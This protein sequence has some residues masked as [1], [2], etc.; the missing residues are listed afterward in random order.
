MGNQLDPASFGGGAYLCGGR[1]LFPRRRRGPAF[2]ECFGSD[3]WFHPLDLI[4]PDGEKV[5]GWKKLETDS[6][7]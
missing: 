4:R 7:L 5:V 3:P 2:F 6:V 1:P